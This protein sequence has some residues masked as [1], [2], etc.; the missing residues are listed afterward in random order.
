MCKDNEQNLEKAIH[1]VKDIAEAVPIY[2]DLVQPA[3]KELGKSLQTVTKLVN[4]ALTPISVLVW[5]YDMIGDFLSKR[6]AE[7]LEKVAEEKIITP[8]PQIAGPAIE[9]L[10]Y[11]GEDINL[12]ELYANLIASAMNKDVADKAHPAYVEILK[13]LSSEEALLLKAFIKQKGYP[14][15][16]LNIMVNHGEVKGA[17]SLY[18]NFSI[19]QKKVGLPLNKVNKYIENLCRLGLL[20]IPEGQIFTS[21]E[22]YLEIEKSVFTD[23]P[24]AARLDLGEGLKLNINRKVVEITVFGQDFIKTVIDEGYSLEKSIIE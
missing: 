7:K 17:H 13:N 11:V 14:L 12:R 18:S 19:F 22:A 15:L 21:K 23:L 16:D 4:I 1:I 3:A 9:A 10:R 20:Q 6:L 2:P 8:S 24:K 5:G